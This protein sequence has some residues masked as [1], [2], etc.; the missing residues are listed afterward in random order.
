MDDDGY[1]E[2]NDDA[3]DVKKAKQEKAAADVA[4]ALT[5]PTEVVSIRFIA[6]RSLLPQDARSWY[7]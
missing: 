3:N 7:T 2:A 4:R 1:D 5:A 6:G